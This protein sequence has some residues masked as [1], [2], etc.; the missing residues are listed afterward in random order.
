MSRHISFRILLVF[1]SFVFFVSLSFN[2]INYRTIKEWNEKANIEKTRVESYEI[3]KEIN[4]K[5]ADLELSIREASLNININEEPG[6][7][8]KKLSLKF[9]SIIESYFYSDDYELIY[10]LKNSSEGFDKIKASLSKYIL[11]N[12]EM[13]DV[14]DDSKYV[15]HY[16]F[17]NGKYENYSMSL[18]IDIEEFIA[19][20]I[21]GHDGYEVYDSYFKKI[22]RSNFDG[23][24]VEIDEKKEAM[25]NGYF[26][27]GISSDEFYSYGSLDSKGLDLYYYYI[28]D[29]SDYKTLIRSYYVKN[30]SLTL[31]LMILSTLVAWRLIGLFHRE[32][33]KAIS[34]EKYQEHEFSI[35]NKKLR[36]AIH[37]I[38]DVM[39]HY[40]ELGHLKEELLE[41]VETLPK[42]GELHDKKD[43]KK[44]LVEKRKKEKNTK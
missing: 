44:L 40:S 25:I 16:K 32:I 26:D 27:V 14:N 39:S 23:D 10:S 5:F 20:D 2:Y 42:E 29:N 30:I 18:I 13:W 28:K 12:T 38:D 35:L 31:F 8:I 4:D 43:L 24:I 34:S 41:I 15:F 1:L 11:T 37:W 36:V 6:Y 17:S 9:P 21:E 3:T 19:S 22:N 33:L 7:Y